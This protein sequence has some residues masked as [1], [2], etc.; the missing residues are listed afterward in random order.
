MSMVVEGIY[1]GGVIKLKTSVEAPN[2]S[3]VLVSFKNRRKTDKEK[4]IKSAGTWKNI[5]V[6]IFNE[7]LK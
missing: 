6:S 1:R 2:N 5:D 3:E 7:I 4:F